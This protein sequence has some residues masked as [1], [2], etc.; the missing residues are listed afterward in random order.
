MVVQGI[1]RR[2]GIGVEC[3]QRQHFLEGVAARFSGVVVAEHGAGRFVGVVDLRGHHQ[4]TEPGQ[5]HGQAADGCGELEDL[6]IQQQPCAASRRPVRRH[7]RKDE[8]AHRPR[9]SGNVQE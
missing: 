2:P 1:Q 3:G 7:R 8:G 9:G 5:L 4:I 6:R